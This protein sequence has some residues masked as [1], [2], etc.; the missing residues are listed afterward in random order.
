MMQRSILFTLLAVALSG[1]V[2]AAGTATPGDFSAVNTGTLSGDPI[3]PGM[4]VPISATEV[5]LTGGDAAVGC[6]GGIFSDPASPCALVVTLARAG[7]YSFS[8]DYNTADGVGPAGDI[9]GVV[10]DGQRLV[11]SD[12]G[13]P[14]TQS[15]SASFT[16]S[17]SFG[18]FINC[19]DC[20]GG[21][22]TVS[23]TQF[24]TTAVPEP[25]SVAMLLAGLAGIGAARRRA[26]PAA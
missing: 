26:R 18:W 23:I 5:Q 20:S 14:I 2:L 1:P 7:D 13:G 12:L 9:F 10:V 6:D 16:A 15:G 21:S 4:A 22:A 11:I 8:W 3:Q 24:S 19:T 17:M 25:A